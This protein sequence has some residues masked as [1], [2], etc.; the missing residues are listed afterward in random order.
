MRKEQ[1]N[2]ELHQVIT[3]LQR[4]L[5]GERTSTSRLCD[6]LR[7]EQ[8][9]RAETNE[10]I[11][12]INRDLTATREQYERRLRMVNEEL[13]TRSGSQECAWTISRDEIEISENQLGQ[14]AWGWVKEGKFR[15]TKVAVKQMYE[16]IVSDHN[17]EKFQREMQM[18]ARCRHP[19][20]LQFIGATNDNGVA[21]LFVTELLDSDLRTV[22]SQRPLPYGEFRTISHDV[23]LALNY[24]HLSNPPII[25]RDISSANVLLWKRGEEWRAKLSD[26]GAA[27]FRRDLMS[28]NPGARI[29]AA[30][31]AAT[32]NQST[33]VSWLIS[34][35][36]WEK[37]SMYKRESKSSLLILIYSSIIFSKMDVFSY[38]V[39]LG[40]MVTR[41]LPEPLSLNETIMSIPYDF[42]RHVVQ[43]CTHRSP[44]QR[45]TIEMVLISCYQHFGVLFD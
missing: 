5:E 40:E 43:M 35:K 31:E 21:A 4:D 25:H 28:E 15:G 12:Q 14:G 33:K 27:N 1:E 18:A 13:R 16:V 29:Y 17:R 44:E 20:L 41:R 8:N 37:P 23:L 11:N 34:I 39:L 30:P 38:G 42:L 10:T 19:N 6:E 24:L 32:T 2:I 7:A 9:L 45:P 3:T 22:L 36:L 26:Y